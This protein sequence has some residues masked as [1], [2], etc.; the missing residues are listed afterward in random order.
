MGRRTFAASV[1]IRTWAIALVVIAAAWRVSAAA[2]QAPP[3]EMTGYVLIDAG[4]VPAP[5]SCSCITSPFTVPAVRPGW[6]YGDGPAAPSANAK[7][8]DAVRKQQAQRDAEERANLPRLAEDALAGNPNA[9]ISLGYD[10]TIGTAIARNDKQAAGWFH[11]AARQGHPDA[12]MQLGYRYSHGVGVPQ[13]DGT[14]AYWYGAG[15]AAGNKGAMIALGLLYA[16]G[17]GVEQDWAAAVHWWTEAAVSG[18][19]LA[20][21]FIADA[22]VCGVGAEQNYQRAVAE[23]RKAA[24]AGDASSSVQL[25]HMYRLGC[26]SA[27]DDIMVAAYQKA[28]DAGD[29]EAQIALG[30]LYLEG[31]GTAQSFYQAYMWSRLAERRLRPGPLRTAAA[32]SAAAAARLMSP[33]EIKD[34]ER[35]VES[36][37]VSGSTPMR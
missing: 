19:P 13:N 32:A 3:P 23:Y 9:S 10:L 29:P 17:R 25:G 16:A 28:A 31:R 6:G 5:S 7:P 27:D 30:E 15:A 37:L 8:S 35:F 36:I 20:S 14:A 24:D 18:G 21:R 4:P 2:R 26:A 22:Y 34:A 33:A 1:L 11:L 12:F